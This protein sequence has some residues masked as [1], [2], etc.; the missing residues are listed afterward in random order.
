MG[1]KKQMCK[2]IVIVVRGKTEGDLD[3]ALQEAVYSVKEGCVTGADS[4]DAGGY[5]FTVEDE[6]PKGDWPA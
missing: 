5:Y 3:E 6:V 4:N 2:R 1:K